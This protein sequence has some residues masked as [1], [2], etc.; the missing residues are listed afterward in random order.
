MLESRKV[1]SEKSPMVRLPEL[2]A[3]PARISTTPVPRLAVLR[4][5][6]S[7]VWSKRCSRSESLRRS[8]LRALK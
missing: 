3:C 5:S 6:E 2:I 4:H 7:R 1:N 8:A